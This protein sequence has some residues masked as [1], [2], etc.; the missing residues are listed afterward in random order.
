MAIFVF[1]Q[2]KYNKT[3]DSAEAAKSAAKGKGKDKQTQA[4]PAKIAQGLT[5]KEAA[6]PKA[7]V[8]AAPAGS[9]SHA[10]ALILRPR[11][12]EKSGVLS[13]MNV[14]TFEV[15]TNAN[16]DSI[17]K[18]IQALYKV[19]PIKVA[20]TKLPAKRV[21]VRGKKGVV[22]GVKKALVTL[23]KGDTIDFV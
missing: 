6:A 1:K 14:Y 2:K 8:P 17:S 20:I 16:K 12:T 18:A 4:K 5:T 23:K 11:V 3:D 22:S 9:Q 13:Q 15:A 21:F 19:S 10:A 7:V